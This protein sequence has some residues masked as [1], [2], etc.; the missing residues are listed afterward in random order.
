MNSQPANGAVIETLRAAPPLT[1]GGL[2]LFG[3][4]LS[5]WV[6]ILTA[7]YTVLQIGFLIRDKVWR[8]YGRNKR[9]PR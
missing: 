1:V 9:N 3:I 7:L 2:T 5:D 6:L 8:H 4:G